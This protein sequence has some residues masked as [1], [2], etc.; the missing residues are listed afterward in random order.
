MDLPIHKEDNGANP[1]SVNYCKR[2]L[3]PYNCSRVILSP[4]RNAYKS[5]G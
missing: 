4:Y 2:K 5:I 1:I 3:R